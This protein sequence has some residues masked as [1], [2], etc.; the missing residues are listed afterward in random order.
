MNELKAIISK[1]ND[2]IDAGIDDMQRE[3]YISIVN[4]IKTDIELQIKEIE[5]SIQLLPELNNS[6][7][8]IRFIIQRIRKNDKITLP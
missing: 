7:S 5:Q 2:V 4:E 8:S 3:S 1:Y 6:L